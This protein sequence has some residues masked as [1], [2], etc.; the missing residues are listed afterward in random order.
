MK[1][2]EY[3][4]EN[5]ICQNC[6]KDFTIE[7]DDFSFY[8]KL[9]IPAPTWCPHCRFIRKMAFINER[10]LYK[11]VCSHC[12]TSIVSIYSTDTSIPVWC[13]KCHIGDDWDACDYGKEYDFSL[14]F[15]EQFKKLKYSTPHR[16]LEQNERNGAGCEYSNLCYTSKDVYL[17]FDVTH[18]EHI[19]YSGNVLAD[20]KNCIDS[21]IIKNNDR[22]YELVQA[23]NNYNSSF[24]I[25]S[26][27]CIDSQFLYDCSNCVN[28]CLSSN[29]RNKSN[30]F[31][32][33]Q[34]SKEEYNN[35]VKALNL[36]TYSGQLLAKEYFA[37]MAKRAI[38]KYAH[39][40]NSVNTVGDFLEN[41]KNLY[42]CYGLA[43]G[44]ENVKYAYLGGSVCKDSQ[45]L[46]FIGR[47]EECYECTLAGRGG[48]RLILSFSC[49]GGSHNLLYCDSCRSCSDCFGCVG[50]SK[51]QYCIL[52][53]QYLKEK[54]FELL[55]KIIQHMNDILY[56][57]KMGRKYPFG[58]CF[59]IELSPF[60]YNETY[61]FKE[62]FLSKNEAVSLG[63][64]WKDAESKSYIP[65]IKE[66]EIPDNINDI[67]NTI[68]DEIIECPN[69]G[70]IETQCAS[71]YKILPDE[72][73]FYRQMNLPI[74]RYCPN[75]RYHQRLV[76]KN[77]FRFYERQC[78][79][80]LSNHNH[81]E[82]CLNN[83]E[84]MYAPNR[85]E[86]I[87]CKECYQKEI[88]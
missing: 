47:I 68:C 35:A 59:P 5:R 45:D 20:N 30:V 9:K 60:G 52:N 82:K 10:S 4:T 1:N 28:C 24:L 70:K 81:K 34:L 13:V 18:S 63:Y 50:L 66:N 65:T 55:P 77:P 31:R 74:P 41:S 26:D 88:Y 67:A 64:R 29:L 62:E 72:L 21:L 53:R 44:C 16:A 43:S 40:K 17:S 87:Y 85:P 2:M 39:I 27:Q 33:K 15:F 56:I 25:E 42:H 73:S 54:Y 58:E 6:K 38:H 14:N 11:R 12:N 69:Q 61:A 51:K 80:E 79:C 71:A 32:N 3:K 36:G 76:W 23:G 37:Q 57:D 8:E 46:L 48:S 83:F 78:M 86:I 7:P 75:C 84:T 19:K 49:G 22:G